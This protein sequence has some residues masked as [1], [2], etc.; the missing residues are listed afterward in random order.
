MTRRLGLLAIV[1]ALATGASAGVGPGAVSGYVKNLQGVP[2]MGAAVQ[3]LTV[4]ASQPQVVYTDARGYFVAAGLLPGTYSLKV[5][6]PSFL[7]SL[8]ENVTIQP[9]ASV[10]VNITLNTLFEAINLVP[11]RANSPEEEEDWKW[12]LRSMSN[13]PILRLDDDGPLVVVSRSD[14]AND[15]ILKA[16][17]AFIAGGA[18]SGFASGSDMSTNFN[19]EQSLFTSGTLGFDGDVAYGSGVPAG[20]LRA[21]YSRTLPDG[22]KPE[23]AL[24]MHRF[25]TPDS[26]PHRAALQALALTMSQ[27]MSFADMLDVNI[28]AEMQ[29]VQFMGRANAVRP[30][31][32]VAAHVSKNTVVEYRYASSVPNTRYLKGFDSAPADLSET[33]PRV[34]MNNGAPLIERAGH[35]E[36]SISQRVGKNNFQAAMY[37]DRLH[38]TA[39]VGIGDELIDTGDMLPDVY[40]GTFTYTGSDLQTRGFRL[41]YNRKLSDQFSATVDYAFGGAL[42]ATPGD[43]DSVQQSFRTAK[44]HSIATKFAGTVPGAKTKWMASYAWMSGDALTPVDMFNV[45]PGQSDPYL[46]FF[47]RQPLPRKFIPAGVE[48]LVDVRNLLAQGYMPVI[49]NDGRSVYLVDTARSVRGGLAFIF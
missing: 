9:G 3:L 20:V 28:G 6:A 40:S 38:N 44:R 16:R 21:S 46:S 27:T 29:T 30:F 4:A 49:G 48:A 23:I 22:S 13:R 14:E 17:V 45:S 47:V 7:P 25:A 1:L 37:Q 41:V 2:Q 34:S 39:L 26:A 15:G 19:V 12:T 43:W 31:G 5:T 32:S 24:T 36:L 18:S 42:T 10:L 11:R 35:H 8:R 33:N